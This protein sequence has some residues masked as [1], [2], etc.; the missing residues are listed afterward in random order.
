MA[1]TMHPRYISKSDFPEHLL[2]TLGLRPVGTRSKRVV[3]ESW[4]IK[5]PPKDALTAEI[6]VAA[7]RDRISKLDRIVSSMT[8]QSVGADDLSHVED[9]SFASGSTKLKGVADITATER[10]WFEVVLHNRGR[11]NVL[12]AFLE[13]AES[14]RARV[15]VVRSRNVGGLTF[16]PISADTKVAERI[17]DFSFLRVARSMPTLRPLQPTI[18]RAITSVEIPTIPPLTRT[19]RALIF[20]G[21]IPVDARE[22]LQ[23]WVTVIEP[24]SVGA[25]VPA[26]EEHGL[27][28]TSAFLF[29]P[30]LNPSALNQP[31]CPVD[32]VRILDTNILSGT[33][34]YYFDV[35]DRMLEYFDAKGQ[36]YDLINLS[37]G[38]R[39]PVDDD[40][41]TL[42]TASWD[43]RLSSGKW[44]MTAATGNDG[45]MDAASGNNRIQPPSDGVNILGVGA[46]DRSNGTWA[47][48]S[49]SCV[50]PGRRP[51]YEKPDGVVFGGSSRE[52]FPVL[53]TASTIEGMQGTSFAA[54]YALRLAASVKAQLGSELNPLAIRALLIHQ[55]SNTVGLPPNE[56]GWGRF[57]ID[58]ARLITCE[59]HEALVIYQGN[60]KP[61]EY[62]RARLPL[63]PNSTQGN[64]ELEATL[65]I[66]TE[67]DPANSWAYTRRGVEVFF[68]PHAEK[69]GKPY[70]GKRP[71]HPKTASFFSASNLYGAS[72][73]SLREQGFKWE[74]CR[75]AK[76]TMRSNS[77]KSPCFDI[78][79]HHRADGVAAATTTDTQFALVLTVRAPR[80]KDFYNR[81]VRAYSNVL[82]PLQPKIQ[83]TV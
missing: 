43:A 46:C 64:V 81:V 61:T 13:Y 40:D 69:F 15:D 32:H 24:T 12:A 14:L 8:A 70:K 6:F 73:S 47:R 76:I 41:V 38:P 11:V 28:V 68:R 5:K 77:L 42:W 35:L 49:Y 21:G 26:F 65:V 22:A 9:V 39:V 3:P 67:V 31:I 66:S 56:I 1:V 30:I 72:E 57:E 53:I 48:S 79:N 34:P 71:E 51:G 60:L 83:I 7:S 37:I 74:P 19:C 59:D 4:G 2:N 55:A 44:I 29:G 80:V 58:P 10:R 18:I 20:D 16:V 63:P 52:Q 36:E 62:L 17:A 25:A 27:G 45:E 54:P 75:R 23:P 82:I 33:D 50:G 78:Y